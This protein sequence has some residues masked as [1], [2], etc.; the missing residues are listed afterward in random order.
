MLVAPIEGGGDTSREASIQ[1]AAKVFMEIPQ[2]HKNV[3]ILIYPK[4]MENPT[5]YVLYINIKMNK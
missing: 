2:Y 3:I 5:Y 1:W 4:K